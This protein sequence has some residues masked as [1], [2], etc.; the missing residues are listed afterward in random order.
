MLATHAWYSARVRQSLS[1]KLGRCPLRRS[2]SRASSSAA[3]RS[4]SGRPPRVAAPTTTLQSHGHPFRWAHL[5]RGRCPA[6]A[7]ACPTSSFQGAPSRR[8]CCSRPSSP[9]L[10][11]EAIR[12]HQM[13]SEAIRAVSQP[14]S[15]YLMREAIRFNQRQSEAIR[16]VSRP[17]S[18]YLAASPHGR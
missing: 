10:M 8:S 9:Y 5:S 16:A 7:A 3:H 17:S 1:M 14:S 13:P 2:H 15:P 18:P 4:T 6:H 11:R 12:C